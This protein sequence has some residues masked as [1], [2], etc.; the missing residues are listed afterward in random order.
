MT[1]KE[2]NLFKK[3]VKKW[4][5]RL[6][7]RDWEIA[8][9]KDDLDDNVVGNCFY[10]PQNRHATISIDKGLKG[11]TDRGIGL[12]ALHETLELLLADLRNSLDSFYNADMV[13]KQIHR[14]IR[15]LENALK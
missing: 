8:V 3:S 2:F 14:V 9:D 10:E 1:K 7:L 6:G 13:D 15:K 12:I 5:D 4:R 11:L